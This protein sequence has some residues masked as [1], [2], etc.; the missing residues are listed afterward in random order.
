MLEIN[1]SYV[2][3]KDQNPI[4]IQIPIAEFEKIEEIL[5]DYGLGK[6]IEEVENDQ[7]LDKE[8]ALQYLELLKNKNMEG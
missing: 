3:D 4:A 7:I 8:K 5:E 6:L 1:K 2:L